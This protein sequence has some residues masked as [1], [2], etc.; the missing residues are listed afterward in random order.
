MAA[1]TSGAVVNALDERSQRDP[2]RDGLLAERWAGLAEAVLRDEGVGR[3]ELGLRFVDPG[4][5]SELNSS[6]M[7]SP[8]P[9]DVLAFPIDGAGDGAGGSVHV[10]EQVPLLGDVVVCPAYAA[11]QAPD[12][13]GGGH[14]GSLG[15]ELALLVV[16]GVLHVLGYDHQS[17]ADAAAMQ[18]RERQLLAAHYRR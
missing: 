6:H 3:G 13:A 7:G 10:P 5:M 18:A 2:E 14:D 1:A 9:T 11:E 12:H 8:G 4:A 15:D 16:H 17:D